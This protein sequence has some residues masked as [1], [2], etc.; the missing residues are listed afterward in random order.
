MKAI[1][2]GSGT[3]AG[4]PP[5]RSARHA[6]PG[7]FSLIEVTLAIGIVS[8][9]MVS[10]MGMLPFGLTHFK[11]AIDTTIEAQIVQAVSS[12]IELADFSQLTPSSGSFDGKEFD[13]D[14]EGAALP[15]AGAPRALY[16]ATVGIVPVDTTNSPLDISAEAYKIQVKISNP[17][18]TPPVY[19]TYSVIVANNGR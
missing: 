9:A 15:G 4:R 18:Q 10:M 12:Q 17:L 14:S 6:C 2:P 3:I 16:R 8:F 5:V 19:H 13:Y 1:R 7:A 11:K